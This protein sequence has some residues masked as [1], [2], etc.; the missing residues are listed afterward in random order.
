MF[1]TAAKQ[2]AVLS[3][4]VCVKS[5]RFHLSPQKKSSTLENV[6]LSIGLSPDGHCA[7][8]GEDTAWAALRLS[9]RGAEWACTVVFITRHDAG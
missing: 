8:T 6:G 1:T 3:N 5:F 9:Q 7:A 2:N 4:N